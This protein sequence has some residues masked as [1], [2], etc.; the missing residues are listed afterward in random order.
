MNHL[1]TELPW[2]AVA[3]QN[4]WTCLW[5]RNDIVCYRIN[6]MYRWFSREIRDESSKSGKNSLSLR[7]AKSFRNNSWKKSKTET[8]EDRTISGRDCTFHCWLSFIVLLNYLLHFLRN[9]TEHSTQILNCL[10]VANSA[11]EIF[12]RLFLSVFF[13]LPRYLSSAFVWPRF[14]VDLPFRNFLRTTITLYRIT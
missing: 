6:D 7:K 5:H 13:C 2:N 1:S 14:Q 3:S 10:I 12:W 4:L 11:T 8:K 9:D